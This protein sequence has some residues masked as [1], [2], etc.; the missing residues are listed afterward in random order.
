MDSAEYHH[1]V[2][3]HISRRLI[4]KFILSIKKSGL[5]PIAAAHFLFGNTIADFFIILIFTDREMFSCCQ[6]YVAAVIGG[7]VFCVNQIRLVD[8]KKRALF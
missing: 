2:L 6:H 5:Q 3:H 8:T 7:H 1:A 4:D